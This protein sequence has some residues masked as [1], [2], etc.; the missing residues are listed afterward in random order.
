[1]QTNRDINPSVGELQNNSS[2]ELIAE[3]SHNQIKEFVIDR[4]STKSNLINSYMIYQII[5]ILTG[6]FFFTRSVLLATGGDL[7]P[8]IYTSAGLIFSFT[9]LIVIHELLHGLS[10]KFTGAEKVT[11]GGILRKFIFY[12]QAD[13]YVMNRKQYAFVALTPLVIIQLVTLAVVIIFRHHPLFYSGIL[14]MSVHSLFCSG[15]IGLLSFFYQ[16]PGHEIYTYDSKAERKSFFYMENKNIE[17]LI[18]EQDDYQGET[19]PQD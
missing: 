18:F 19:T 5:M 4:L 13:K 16:F 9:L 1:M 11:F 15:D 17:N 14:V 2:Y 3:L 6:I 12:A 7:L 8:L 10:L